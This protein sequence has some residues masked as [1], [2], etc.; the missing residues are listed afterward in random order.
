MIENLIDVARLLYN[1]KDLLAETEKQLP[2][3]A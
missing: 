3:K 2:V 1:K